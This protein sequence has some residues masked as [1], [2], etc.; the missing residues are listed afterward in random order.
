MSAPDFGAKCRHGKAFQVAPV[1]K[2]LPANAKDTREVGLIPGLG[3][4]PLEDEMA[5]HSNI[6]AWKIPRTEEPE[7]DITEHTCTHTCMHG[8][9]NQDSFLT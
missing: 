6:L 7:S 2:N 9:R 8:R 5:L 1:I 3:K 4:N